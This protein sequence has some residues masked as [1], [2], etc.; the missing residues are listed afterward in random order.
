MH[1]A[2][3]AV[4][5]FTRSCLLSVFNMESDLQKFTQKRGEIISGKAWLGDTEVLE[6]TVTW[7][8]LGI[9]INPAPPEER[10]GSQRT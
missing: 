3:M 1:S 6:L 9:P 2:F 8:R 10:V 4:Q 5:G 7:L